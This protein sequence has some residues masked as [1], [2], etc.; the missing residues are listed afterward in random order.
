MKSFERFGR[1]RQLVL[2]EQGMIASG[3]YLASLTGLNILRSGGNAIDAAI[4]ASATLAVLRPHMCGIGG[5]AF[6]IY[7][8]Q[9]ANCRRA[10]NGSG[11]SPYAADLDSFWRRALHQVPAKGI[12]SATVPGLVDLW[13]EAL[14]CHGTMEFSEVAADAIQYAGE[15]FPAYQRLCLALQ[16]RRFQELAA[17]ERLLKDTYYIQGRPPHVGEKIQQRHLAASLKA[18]AAKGREAFYGGPLTSQIV[19]A[20]GSRGG[21]FSERDF[22]EHRS[23]WVEPLRVDYRGCDILAFPPNTQGVGL[24]EQLNVL[25]AVGAT[26]MAY[27]SAD[28]L[29]VMI[30][31]KKRVFED[32]A[33][34]VTDPQFF[35]A[36]LENL[37]SK[38]YANDLG[39]HVLSHSAR[40]RSR[41]DLNAAT[42]QGGDT[43]YL[44]VVDRDR[45][46][47]SLILSLYES[48]GSG[49]VLDET[50]IILHNR[51]KGFS[52]N[53]EHVNRIEPH[54][55]PF[56]TLCPAMMLRDGQPYLVYG[57]PGA[58][59][60]TQTLVQVTNNL[61]VHGMDLQD[62][63]EAPRFRH[64]E[65]AE[66]L[67]EFGY[68]EGTY[69]ELESRGHKLTLLSRWDNDCGG[70]Q[71]IMI[72]PATKILMGGADPRRDGVA[73][74]Y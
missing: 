72:D 26:S 36:P 8:D 44:C 6:M 35:S 57:T 34:Y 65:G 45:N 60:Q 19:A 7:H 74:G 32:V 68:E 25:D 69:K 73:L 53:P 51:G 13:F 54:K 67:I 62:A 16:G 42:E 52:L 58:S 10:L 24:L 71:A 70:V 21:L 39:R 29:H 31:V 56:H 49:V 38:Q 33:R 3:H 11:R 20:S 66:S 64:T 15:G 63:I 23:T 55:R 40:E 12:L 27:G 43:T 9:R 18:I 59:G 41:P 37:L 28:Y 4:G 61:L 17:D 1:G 5:D 46:C 47:V 48:F 50:G 14:A 22:A 30:E 2:G